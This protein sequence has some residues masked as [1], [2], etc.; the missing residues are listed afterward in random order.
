M[1]INTAAPV[2]SRAEIVIHAPIKTIWDI[3]ADVVIAR[4]NP[5]IRYDN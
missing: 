2:I 1:D 3:Q 5:A 4:R